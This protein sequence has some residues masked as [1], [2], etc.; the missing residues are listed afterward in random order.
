MSTPL[1]VG[2]L[3]K[4]RFQ[5]LATRRALGRDWGTVTGL[6]QLGR[7]LICGEFLFRPLS[8]RTITG[9][10]YASTSGRLA[11]RNRTR[12]V[13][14]QD[15]QGRTTSRNKGSSLGPLDCGDLRVPDS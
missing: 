14:D 4:G 12:G 2:L 1:P 10:L 13:K 5:C 7:D 8:D 15:R 11:P 6:T 3:P 9:H